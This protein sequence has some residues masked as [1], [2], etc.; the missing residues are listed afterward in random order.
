MSA[1]SRRI[2]VNV[3]GGYV[4][5]VNFIVAG[6]V[7]AAREAGLEIVGIRDGYEGLRSNGFTIKVRAPRYVISDAHIAI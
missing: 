7:L 6:A 3:G 4:S 2:A 5:G 1:P